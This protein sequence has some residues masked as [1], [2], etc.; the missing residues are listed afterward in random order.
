V[1]LISVWQ[2][3]LSGALSVSIGVAAL[4]TWHGNSTARYALAILVLIH[5]GLITY[6]N[7]NMAVTGV[8]V[9]GSSAILWGRIIRSP[10]TAAIIAGY[11][12]FSRNAS[13]FCR[14]RGNAV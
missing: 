10:I 2:F 5:Y 3:V 8:E 12:L 13:S 11:L 6:Q 1:Q 14:P 4:L 9:R 7:Y